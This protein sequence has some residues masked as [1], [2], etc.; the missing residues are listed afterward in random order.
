MKEEEINI[1]AEMLLG[2]F[3]IALPYLKPSAQRLRESRKLMTK[4]K[5]V[6]ADKLEMEVCIFIGWNSTKQFTLF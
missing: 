1:C 5:K 3:H 6:N 2:L 4:G